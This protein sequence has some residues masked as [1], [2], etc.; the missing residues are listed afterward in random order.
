MINA[1]LETNL[2]GAL[3]AYPQ[4]IFYSSLI[5]YFT[6]GNIDWLMLSGANLL[7]N[8]INFFLK[9]IIFTPLI[10][11]KKWPVF[12]YGTRPKGAKHC[13]TFVKPNSNG[14]PGTYGMPSGHAQTA[15]FF[16]AYIILHLINSNYNNVTKKSGIAFF[17]IL[18]IMIMYSRI[19]FKCHTIQ[20]VLVGGLIGGTLGVLYFKNKD[21]IKK[22]INNIF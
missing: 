17:S 7:N 8:S 12:G 1:H 10:G 19:Y 11:H 20:Q 15:M 13:G 21:K 2:F 14:T 9:N 6:S 22:K 18:G 4:I 3:R 16:S 5:S